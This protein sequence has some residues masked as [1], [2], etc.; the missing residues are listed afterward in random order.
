MSELHKWQP[1]NGGAVRPGWA[2]GN[3]KCEQIRRESNHWWTGLL[4]MGNAFSLEPWKPED[5]ELPMIGVEARF[6]LC[7]EQCASIA[8]SIYMKEVVSQ[9]LQQK[10]EVAL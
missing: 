6:A 9:A 5:F 1:Q 2:C 3:P 8:Q 10:A 7:G 4:L